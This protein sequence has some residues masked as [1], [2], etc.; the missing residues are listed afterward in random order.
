MAA[1]L[2]E[3][4]G[5]APAI[6]ISSEWVEEAAKIAYDSVATPV[7][8][9]CGAKNCGKTTFSRYL[10]NVLLQRYRK[11]A[12]LDTD[13]GQSEFTPPGCLS[14][15]VIDS[16]PSDLAIPCMK[17]PERCFFFGDTSSK[18]DPKAYLNYIFALYDYYQ[19]EYRPPNERNRVLKNG[20]PL[21]VNTPGWVK[22]IGY[23]ILVNMIQHM[24]PTH[25]VKINISAGSKNLPDGRFWLNGYNAMALT[26]AVKLK[27][28]DESKIQSD[29]RS[30]DYDGRVELI[31]I[32]AARK[33]SSNR[34]I[35]VQKDASLLRDLKIMAYFRQIFPSNMNVTTIKE[36]AQALTSH[37]PYQVPISAVKIKHLYCQIP[38]SEVF[39]SLNASI[40]GLVISPEDSETP[41]HCIGLGRSHSTPQLFEFTCISLHHIYIWLFK[42]FGVRI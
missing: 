20:L 11:V 3:N 16:L 18:R 7:T 12:Y 28:L 34:S 14:L 41:P 35:L 27:L 2:S 42:F 26:D 15:T 30:E 22:G 38:A 1:A 8:V 36:L 40:V 13:V 29:L 19:S 32:D 37:P 6:T 31:E 5:L 17:T 33:D 39:Y 21:V 4:E 10:L 24:S 9:V 25:V 23:D